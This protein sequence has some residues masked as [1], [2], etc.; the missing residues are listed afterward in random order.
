M[1]KM[2]SLLKKA[3]L[4]SGRIIKANINKRKKV[5]YKGEIDLLTVTDKRVEQT[6]KRLIKKEFPSHC[7]VG[8]EYG[9]SCKGPKSPI[10]K[11]IIDP[12]DGT[13]N[14]YHSFPQVSTSIAVEHSGTIIMG[15]VYDPLRDELYFA[16]NGKGAFCNGKK[17]SVSSIKSLRKSLL[18]TG[19]PYDRRK[20]VDYYLSFFKAFM[21]KCHGIR[22]GGSAALDFCF[23]ACGRIDGF[24]E[25]KLHPW[26]VAAGSLI[27]KEAGG[28]VTDFSGNP[29]DVYGEQ[30]LASNRLI[31][32]EMRRVIKRTITNY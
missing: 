2:K 8:E 9:N 13:T 28:K 25:L 26:D 3:L 21:M 4:T 16:E 1:S 32:E 6:I 24:W 18:I 7:I 12:I 30:T 20:Y 22:R 29:Y 27:V 10:Y 31:H 11:W 14:F 19:F 15:G 5:E 23:V 17:I